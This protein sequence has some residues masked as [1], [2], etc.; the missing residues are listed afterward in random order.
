MP[1]ADQ[2][3]WTIAIEAVLE[4]ADLSRQDHPDPQIL[5][6]LIFDAKF[7]KKFKI[8]KLLPASIPDIPVGSE[9][10]ETPVSLM[11]GV[12]RSSIRL[13]QSTQTSAC[14]IRLEQ[15]YHEK[16]KIFKRFS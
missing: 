12:I 6:I 5:K 16:I 1:W 9:R 13:L 4:M 8:L 3:T 7:S 10:P 14:N 15:Q 2:V 11:L